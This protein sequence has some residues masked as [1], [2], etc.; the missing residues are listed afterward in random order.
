MRLT[1]VSHTGFTVSHLES[2]L[3]FYCGLLGMKMITQQVGAASYLSTITGFSNV[4]L[5]IALL[6]TG[7]DSE[8][9]LELLEYVSN[10]GTPQETATNRPGNGHLCFTVE[11]IWSTYERLKAEGVSFKS[12]P[13]GITE[14]VNKGA[15]AVY[16]LDPDGF[17][18]ELF[19]PAPSHPQ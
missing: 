4:E 6:K 11:D 9:I 7:E 15:S 17:T 1:G 18:L 5:K 10:Q 2:S 14:G 12:L 16:F 3:R 8:H 19:Q 13:V